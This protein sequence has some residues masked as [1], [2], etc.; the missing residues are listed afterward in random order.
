MIDEPAGIGFSVS[1]GS[2]PNNSAT[3]ALLLEQFLYE[4][5]KTPQLV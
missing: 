3:N 4:F 5:F 2:I 1:N